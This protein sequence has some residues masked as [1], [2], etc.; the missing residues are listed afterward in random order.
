MLYGGRGASVGPSPIQGE[1][2]HKRS[3]GC[4]MTQ[5]IEH[6]IDDIYEAAMLPELWP[7][8]LDRLAKAANA[9]GGVLFAVD[10]LKR[11]SWTVRTCR[12]GINKAGRSS[13]AKPRC[14]NC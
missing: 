10:A 9:A 2:G 4:I 6:I 14:R 13:R 7:V 8:V 12:H 5:L 3:A 1:R 11:G